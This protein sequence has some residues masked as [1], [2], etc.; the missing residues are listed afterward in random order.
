MRILVDQ[1]Q[2]GGIHQVRWDGRDRQ[3]NPVGSGVY[4]YRLEAGEV[5]AVRKM[6]LVR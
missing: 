3:G 6:V 4:F 5:S 1:V 2:E